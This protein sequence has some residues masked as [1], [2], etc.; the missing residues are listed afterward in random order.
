MLRLDRPLPHADIPWQRACSSSEFFRI[1]AAA[2]RN[3]RGFSLVLASVQLCLQMAKARRKIIPL[4]RFQ[5][6]RA[7]RRTRLLTGLFQVRVL[8]GELDSGSPEES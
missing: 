1:E 6:E 4:L 8:V 3:F 5:P 7:K 2:I